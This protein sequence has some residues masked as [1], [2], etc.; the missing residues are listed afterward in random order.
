MQLG[1]IDTHAEYY[2]DNLVS[3]CDVKTHLLLIKVIL[4]IAEELSYN[5]ELRQ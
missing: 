1:H 2:N 5:S 4:Q 3:S